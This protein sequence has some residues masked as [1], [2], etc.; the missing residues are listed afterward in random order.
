MSKQKK[1]DN[2]FITIKDN[3][4]SKEGVFDYSG[5]QIGAD[6]KNKIFKVYRPAEELEKAVNSFKLVPFVDDHAMLGDKGIPAENKGVQGTT[7]ED[8]YFKDGILYA[9]LKIFSEAV[10]NLIENGKK[11]LSCGYTCKY[12]FK[13][14]TFK[15]QPYEVIQRDIKGNHVALVEAGRM[16]KQVAVLDRAAL[17]EI[18]KKEDNNMTIKELDEKIKKL[19]EQLDALKAERA[20]EEE[21]EVAK[22]DD[23]KKDDDKKEKDVKD[24]EPKAEEKKKDDEDAKKDDKKE[25]KE[26]LDAALIRKEIIKDIAERDI[27]VAKLSPTIGTCDHA[28][29]DKDQYIAYAAKKLGLPESQAALDGYIAGMGAAKVTTAQDSAIVKSDT[30]DNYIKGAK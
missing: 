6:D 19:V 27:Y 10:K 21:E 25:E 26:G 14:G 22:D 28:M 16:G 17:D 11:E 3:P 2:G 5:R 20:K 23:V 15:G 1:D 29:M 30:L 9:N 12:E 13:S 8:V 4:I 7:G 24:D 18:L